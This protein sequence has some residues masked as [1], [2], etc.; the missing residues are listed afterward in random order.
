MLFLQFIHGFRGKKSSAFFVWNLM[1]RGV[2]IEIRRQK[3]VQDFSR[4][5]VM[6]G[7]FEGTGSCRQGTGP[8]SA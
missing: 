2:S 8:G 5:R 3:S 4:I 1:D 7:R 6:E